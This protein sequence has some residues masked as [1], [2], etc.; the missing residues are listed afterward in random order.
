MWII[1]SSWQAM[2]IER[3][4]VTHSGGVYIGHHQENTCVLCVA[5]PHLGSIDDVIVFM[6]FSTCLQSKGVTP[7]LGFRQAEASNLCDMTWGAFKEVQENIAAN[8]VQNTHNQSGDPQCRNCKDCVVGHTLRD[9]GPNCRSPCQ[10]TA[11]WGTALSELVS[12]VCKT[13]CWSACSGCR[14]ARP[15]R[16]PPS[17]APQWPEW[18]RRTWSQCRRTLGQSQCPWAARSQNQS[19]WTVKEKTD[20]DLTVTIC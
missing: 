4:A 13:V 2:R 19:H 15:R 18:R 9:S 17:P 7:R 10:S 16:G 20:T 5:D 3:Q 1:F 6:L 11:G 14:R 12:P 8:T